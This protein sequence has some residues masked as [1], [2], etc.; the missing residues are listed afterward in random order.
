MVLSVLLPL[1]LV[2][3]LIYLIHSTDAVNTIN[4]TTAT[5]TT[6]TVGNE[7]SDDDDDGTKDVIRRGELVTDVLAQNG[8]TAVLP[9]MFTHPGLVTWIRRKDKQFLTLGR[10]TYSIDTR[11]IVL[12][13]KPNWNLWIKNVKHEDGG[14][15][16]CH[17]QSEPMKQRLIRLNI[18]DAYSVIPGSPDLHIKQGSNLRLECRLMAAAETPSY[19]FWYRDDRMINYDNEPGVKVEATKN[20]SVLLVDKVRLSHGANYTCSPSNAKPSY[21]RIH[22]I[23]EEEN[24]AAMHGGSERRNSTSNTRNNVWSIYF[25]LLFSVGAF[26]LVFR[27]NSLSTT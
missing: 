16:E 23:E 19:I 8:G 11:F 3:T 14:I 4:T 12:P 25:L 20:G 7:K 18:T 5:T 17:I 13:D 10:I 24:P 15:Y 22:V 6:T 1:L 9:C 26:E 27:K 21:I 2:T